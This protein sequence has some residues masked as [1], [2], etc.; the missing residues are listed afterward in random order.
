MV[1]RLL[2][3]DDAFTARGPGVLITPRITADQAPGEAPFTV[4]LVLPNGS[5]R[6][7][8][9]TLDIAHMR[10]ALSPWAMVRLYG[11]TVEEVP[12]GTE[13]WPTT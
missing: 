6:E 10:G 2:V 13:V 8:E 1:R 9:A 3:V 4:R 7:V 11:V 12:A 5:S